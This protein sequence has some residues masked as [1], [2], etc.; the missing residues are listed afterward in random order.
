[1]EQSLDY[2]LT[3]SGEL[4]SQ[5]LSTP[6]GDPKTPL[7]Q[8]APASMTPSSS[9]KASTPSQ[10]LQMAAQSF[11]E[12]S[13]RKNE[14]TPVALKAAASLIDDGKE[15][16]ATRP[17]EMK[18]AMELAAGRVEREEH[19]EVAIGLRKVDPGSSSKSP[20]SK[21]PRSTGKMKN[22]PKQSAKSPSRNSQNVQPNSQSML[23]P[24]VSRSNPMPP[25][26]KMIVSSTDPFGSLKSSSE[27]K[28]LS[29]SQRTMLEM[30]RVM[31][32]N[33]NASRKSKLRKSREKDGKG[34]RDSWE[35]LSQPEAVRKSSEHG[36]FD[37][38]RN[39]TFK[40]KI[41]KWK[42]GEQ[43]E[44][45]DDDDKK[46]PDPVEKLIQFV[47]RQDASTMNDRKDKK[48][49]IAAKA[50][51][52]RLDK[53]Q[54]RNCG[55][56]Q[57]YDEY[58]EKRFKCP[59]DMC[60]HGSFYQPK[61][62]FLR[63]RIGDFKRIIRE[64]YTQ[65]EDGLVINKEKVDEMDKML[66]GL[67]PSE[68]AVVEKMAREAREKLMSEEQKTVRDKKIKDAK[69]ASELARLEEKAKKELLIKLTLEEKE[70]SLQETLKMEQDRKG[71]SVRKMFDKSNRKVVEV[72]F[73]YDQPV[74]KLVSAEDDEND[75]A[76]ED[77]SMSSKSKKALTINS[78]VIPWVPNGTVPSDIDRGNGHVA[79]TLQKFV[80]KPDPR[81]AK[82]KD[83]IFE[84]FGVLSK[85]DKPNEKVQVKFYR[86]EYGDRYWGEDE[87]STP[88]YEINNEEKTGPFFER[89][90]KDI[91]IRDSK[92]K[93]NEDKN[94]GKLGTIFK[95]RSVIK[96]LEQE[97]EVNGKLADAIEERDLQVL[98]RVIHEANALRV[99]LQSEKLKQAVKLERELTNVNKLLKEG[100]SAI[101]SGDVDEV[102]AWQRKFAKQKFIKRNSLKVAWKKNKVTMDHLKATK[103]NHPRFEEWETAL[104]D[105]REFLRAEYSTIEGDQNEKIDELQEDMEEDN[106]IMNDI[107]EAMRMKD[108][109]GV[110]AALDRALDKGLHLLSGNKNRVEGSFFSRL[111]DDVEKRDKR[112]WV[113]VKVLKVYPDRSVYDVELQDGSEAVLH[114]VKHGLLRKYKGG[115]DGEEGEDED[116]EEEEEEEEEEYGSDEEDEKGDNDKFYQKKKPPMHKENAMLMARRPEVRPAPTD[117]NVFREE[118]PRCGPVI[119][120]KLNRRMEAIRHFLNNP[121]FPDSRSASGKPKP[122]P[123]RNLMYAYYKQKKQVEEM[124][125]ASNLRI[126]DLEEEKKKEKDDSDEEEEEDF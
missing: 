31:S 84:A 82:A 63:D 40:P 62:V 37:D 103:S 53:W 12:P 38:N 119:I 1:M 88:F 70:K 105:K 56:E 104:E 67:E 22:V 102:K 86:D 14:T 109:E 87:N 29:K 36:A 7:N 3:M 16:V 11:E 59:A 108:L 33:P 95:A 78:K 46:K 89:L 106:S 48:Y 66:K 77:G 2:S 85:D 24:K 116:V 55:T 113:K 6:T 80:K 23:M 68:K 124:M 61:V 76:T 117:Y 121:K 19:R 99:P 110:S 21:S 25:K 8:T 90:E 28:G 83:E 9:N 120:K 100:N 51:N 58:I 5:K 96:Q 10:F 69:D 17:S 39:C 101:K 47:K 43:K 74:G 92:A 72:V 115:D 27:F 18:R 41:K 126:D 93:T 4:P 50:Y 114:A 118:D 34:L 20:S 57:S 44:D 79:Y 30:S 64:A 122:N 35:R 94:L 49:A 112:M 125:R 123:L 91:Q 15:K 98:R 60:E 81:D 65:E 71:I 52:L 26:K 13:D 75:D 32:S 107:K 73:H 42:G 54:C 97:E 111:R 45:D